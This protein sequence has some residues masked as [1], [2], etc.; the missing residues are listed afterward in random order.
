MNFID[1]EFNKTVESKVFPIAFALHNPN[2]K[3]NQKINLIQDKRSFNLQS[4]PLLRRETI[5]SFNVIAEARTFLALGIN[6]LQFNWVDLFLE[7]RCL[8]NNNEKLSYGKQLIDGK[9]VITYVPRSE[10]YKKFIRKSHP[11]ARFDDPPE[12][13]A[14]AVYKLTGNK[15]DCAQKDRMRDLIL[16]KSKFSD[17]EIRKILDYCY[18]DVVYLPLLFKAILAEYQ[19]RGVNITDGTL[20]NEMFW[21]AEYGVRTAIIES[22]GYP[23]NVSATRNFSNSVETILNECKEEINEL[24]PAI[25]P[26][27]YNPKKEVFT[28]KEGRLRCWIQETPHAI[29]WGKTKGGQLSLS[30]EEWEKFYNFRHDYPKDNFGAQMV[31]YFKLKQSL[32]GFMPDK[33]KKKKTIWE[34]LGKD[35]RVRPYLNI[36]RSQ[37]SRNQPSSIGFI[38]LKAAWMRSLIQP[39]RGYAITG[40]DF[41]S[42]EFLI[43]GV[44]S[45]DMVKIDAYNSGDVYLAYGKGTGYIPKEAT[46]KSHKKERDNCKPIV[47]GLQFDMSK[48]GLAV[49]LTSQWG[50]EVSEDEAQVWIDKYNDLYWKSSEAKEDLKEYY[51]QVR[52]L[53][54]FDGWYL[55]G[56]NQNLRS[57]G[58]FPVQ[59]AG[60]AILRR[61]VKYA[62]EMGLVV[63]YTLHD[64]IYIL[65]RSDEVES[66]SKLC[67]AMCRAF[68]D[69]FPDDLKEHANVRLDGNTWSP[70]FS[71]ETVEI[72]V[73]GW[74]IKKQRIYIDDRSIEDYKKFS[75][76]FE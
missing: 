35:G 51:Q 21:R 1:T 13:L 34:Y 28:M 24:F 15:I 4:L 11:E 62:Q 44:L 72:I 30:T 63:S 19:S 32:N 37:T 38:P 46:K 74:K 33:T 9:E 14:G 3:R 41:S 5:C 2:F 69:Y 22:I 76:Y 55:W 12:N 66:I 56:D 49:H 40:M 75:K 53:K 16:S 50:R 43:D 61:A 47:L 52:K 54:L 65:H 7:Y 71:D 59:G 73:D 57:V 23:I 60:G 58:N 8:L 27:E 20:R 18:S 45:Q 48:V 10:D 39:P 25:E 42:Q 29:R 70:D 26:F 64:A 67:Q 31:R 17:W 6:P 36:Y 68:K